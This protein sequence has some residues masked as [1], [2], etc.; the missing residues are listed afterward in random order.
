MKE[1][2]LIPTRGVI[3]L[4]IIN[5][6]NSMGMETLL[7]HSP[8]D[9]L[10]LPVKLADRSY[11]FYSSRLEDS[12]LDGEAI[13]EKAREVRADYIHPGYGFLAENPEFAR[14]CRASNIRFVGPDA[15]VLAAVEDKIKLRE[16][17]A[18]LGLPVLKFS[19]LIKSPL[20]FEACAGECNYPI[21]IKPL[22]GSGGR[23]IRVADY[24]RD[25]QEQVAN[26]LKREENVRS[27]I[28]F[29]EFRPY[30]RHVEIPF[31]RDAKDNILFLPEIESSIQR[32]FQKIFQESP[33]PSINERMRARL[34][35]SAQALLKKIDY[36]GLGYVEFLVENNEC[37]FSEI[38]PTF[39]INTLISEVH[40]T[41][42]FLKKQVVIARGELL[43][44]VHGVRIVKP[45]HHVLLV[46]LMAEDP[47]NNFLPSTGQIGHFFHYSTIRNV[48]KTTLYTGARVTPMYDP[49]IGKILTYAVERPNAINDMRI[50]LDNI[51]IRGIRTN[52]VFLKHLLENADLRS[53]DTIIDFLH[54]KFD[55]SKLK[56]TEEQ[57]LVAAAL[58]AADFHLDNR[59]KNYKAKLEKMKQPGLLKRL[60]SPY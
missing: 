4:D 47:Y 41:S 8:E 22:K 26:L 2:V 18:A 9:S 55:F 21:I 35:E 23:G 33:S 11:K 30:A 46:S 17:A 13:L 39:Q 60:F 53:G 29:E 10:S 14:L 6:L 12:Y 57:S 15:G 16:T 25:A 31:F 24:R 45:K 27:G 7:M 58:L 40:L 34:Y 56:N 51:I 54:L 37:L 32:R 36:V 20:D 48:F 42:N 52:L 1:K 50:F 44:D 38:N 28:F 43:H 49:F 59:K 19:N 3:A 5:S